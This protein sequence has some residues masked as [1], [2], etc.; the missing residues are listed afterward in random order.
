MASQ[1]KKIHYYSQ[2]TSSDHN[3]ASFEDSPLVSVY[4][5]S[6]Q[7]LKAQ[8]FIPMVV[9]SMPYVVPY[10]F[11]EFNTCQLIQIIFCVVK[12]LS[13]Q[14]TRLILCILI[15]LLH[16][17]ESSKEHNIWAKA[18]IKHLLKVNQLIR[19]D[20]CFPQRV[21]NTGSVESTNIL[22]GQKQGRFSGKNMSFNKCFYVLHPV[23]IRKEKKRSP[24]PQTNKMVRTQGISDS[25]TSNIKVYLT[26]GANIFSPRK[27]DLRS[28]R[29]MVSFQYIL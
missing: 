9:G 17:A 24:S 15:K 12:G 22:W 3:F 18:L 10:T 20:R 13:H 2:P 19:V 21:I 8:Y 16:C 5:S 6:V 28:Q 25:V 23:H 29:L 14:K 1:K 7:S 4:S 26:K 27:S 11:I